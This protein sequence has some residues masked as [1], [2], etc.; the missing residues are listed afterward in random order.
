MASQIKTPG[1]V[2][3]SAYCWTGPPPANGGNWTNPNNLKTQDGNYAT[4]TWTYNGYM[5]ANDHPLI[6]SN[7][8]FTIP[9]GATIS[10]ISV[11]VRGHGSHTGEPQYV[12]VSFPWLYTAGGYVIATPEDYA[13][14]DLTDSDKTS[15]YSFYPGEVYPALFNDAGLSLGKEANPCP[16]FHNGCQS[17]DSLVSEYVDVVELTV[18]FNEGYPHKVLGVPAANIGNIMGVPSANVGK[19]NGV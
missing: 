6:L 4:C 5:W 1:T 10:G 15:S 16:G 8:G 13:Y 3:A 18:E 17:S 7:F 11:R 14:F 19:F 9:T 12:A 2:T